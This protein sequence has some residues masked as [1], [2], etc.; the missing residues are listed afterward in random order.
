[1]KSD[2][3]HGSE[4]LTDVA[5]AIGSSLGTVVGKTSA[6]TSEVGRTATK[7][8]RP[9]ADSRRTRKKTGR[10]RRRVRGGIK[11]KRKRP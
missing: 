4:L 1:M 5:R 3:K 2:A 11:V 6:F 8:S 10:A 7:V 9:K